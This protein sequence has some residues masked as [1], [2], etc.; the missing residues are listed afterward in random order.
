MV[1]GRQLL[2]QGI[3]YGHYRGGGGGGIV[4]GFLGFCI[5]SSLCLISHLGLGVK[6]RV[7]LVYV[8]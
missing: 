1:L 3:G 5:R 2:P 6:W 7:G 4:I 8:F